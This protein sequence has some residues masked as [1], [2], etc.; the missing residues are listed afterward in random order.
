MGQRD[1]DPNLGLPLVTEPQ[2]SIAWMKVLAKEMKRECLRI[3]GVMLSDLVTTAPLPAQ[4][5]RERV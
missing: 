5:G 1:S 4:K 2:S 3:Y